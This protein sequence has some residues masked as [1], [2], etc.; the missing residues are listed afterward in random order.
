LELKTNKGTH[1]IHITHTCTYSP[2]LAVFH[3]FFTCSLHH[4][5]SIWILNTMKLVT[6]KMR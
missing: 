1:I 6:Q 5:I 3:S 2:H 4:N